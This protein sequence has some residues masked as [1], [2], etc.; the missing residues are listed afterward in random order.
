[1]AKEG[2]P[3]TAKEGLGS[4]YMAKEGGR[5]PFGPFGHP[6]RGRVPTWPKEGGTAPMAKP[7]PSALWPNEGGPP[8]R[9]GPLWPK[10]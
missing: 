5:E 1:M 9:G 2:D 3:H 6:L 10:E 8:L 7:L 4:A